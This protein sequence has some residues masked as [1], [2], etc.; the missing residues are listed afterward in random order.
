MSDTVK[1]LDSIVTRLTLMVTGIL[2][3]AVLIAG[4]VALLGQQRQLRQA[5]GTKATTLVQ[6]VAQVTPLD[7]LS[8][9]FV[10]MNNDVKKVV[11]TDDEAAYAVILNEQGIPLVSFFKDTDSSVASEVGDLVKNRKPLAAMAAMKRGGRII[12]VTAP[13]AAGEK[14]IGSVTLGLSS[15]KMRHALR[16]QIVA[17]GAVLVVII[18]LSITLLREVL[19]R[20]LRPVR[21]LT[22]AATQISAGDLNVVLTGTDRADELGVLSRAFVGMAGQL[23]GLIAGLERQL[24]FL[25]TLLQTIPMAVFYKD[26]EGRYLG[27]NEEFAKIT[28]VTKEGLAGKTVYEL[29]PGE[30]SETYHRQDLDLLKNP[31]IQVYDFKLRNAK[32]EL[33]DVEYH[34]NVFLDEKG[35][36]AGVIG[37]FLDITDRKRAEE[38]LLRERALLSRITETSPVG[39]TMANAEGTITFANRQAERM[40][41]LEKSAITQRAYN[42]PEWRI[43]DLDGGP[44]PNEQLPF[45]QVVASRQPVFD[46][47]HAIEWPNG[48]RVYLSIN[49][50]PLLSEAGEIEG[51]VFSMEDVSRKKWAEDALR[52]SEQ[53]YRD[54]FD[55]VLDGLYLLEVTPDG[56]FRTVEVNP[57]LERSTGIPRERVIGRTQ[58]ETI[59]AE[60]AAIVNAK[61]RRCVEVGAP[62]EEEVNLDLP[63]GSRYY[64]ST[65][66]PARDAAGRVNR[67]IGISRDVTEL[68]KA[69]A[70]RS[71]HLRFFESMDKVNQAIQGTNDLE[72]MMS[73]VL[74]VVLSAFNGD[75]A[76]IVYPCDPEAVSYHVPMERTTPEYP[77]ALA[78]G[79]EVPVDAETVRVFRTLL[80]SDNPVTFGPGSESPLPSDLTEFFDVHSQIAMAVYPKMDKPYMFGVHQCSY[81]RIWTAE[82]TKLLREIGR[83][84]ADALTSLLSHRDLQESEAKYRRIVDTAIEGI[85][86][87][88]PEVTTKFVNARMADML[89]HAAGEMIGRPY[90]DYMFEEDLPD[91]HQRM[92]NR[93]KGLSEAYERRFRR[94]DGNSVWTLVSATPIFDDER[95]FTGSFGMFTDI[96]E[97]KRNDSINASRL[98]LMQFAVTHSLD[99]LLEET[100]NE[101]EKVSGSLI[102]FY[103]FVDD[104]QQTL[105]LQNWSARTKAVFCK[106]A[107]KGSHYAIADAGVWVDCVYQR[108][109]VVHNDYASLPHRKGMPAGHA[110]VVRELVVPVLRGGKVKAIL[111]IGNKPADY[112]E[113]DVEV[114]ALL[115]DIAWEIAERKSAEE[116]LRRLNRQLRAISEC[117]QTLM[118]A[119]DEQTLLNDIC[120][121]I[122]DQAGYRMAWVGY[123]GQD[124]ARSVEP[125]AAA[126]IEDGYIAEARLSW[127]DTERGRGPAGMA[128]RGGTTVTVQDLSLSREFAPWLESAGKHGYRSGTW[129]PLKDERGQVFGILPI[130]SAQINAFSA[131]EIALLEELAGDLAFGIMVLR[132]RM[133]R[134]ADERSITLMNFALNNV[135]EA[136]F[137]ID[138]QAHFRYVNDESCRLLDYSREELLA[139]SVTDVDPDFPPGRWPDHWS[140]LKA[141]RSLLFEGRHQ[142]RDGR[143]VPVEISANYFEYEGEGLNLALARDI[144][145]RKRMEATLRASEQNLALHVTQTPLGVIEWNLNFEVIKWNPAAERIFGYSRR[146]ALGRHASLIVPL[147]AKEHVDEVWKALVKRKGGL[148]STNENRTKDGRRIFCEWYNTPLVDDSGSV[149]AVASLVQDVTERKEAEEGLREREAFIRDILDSVDEGF[150]VVNRDYRIVSANRAFCSSMN[151]SEDQVVGRLCHEIT[152]RLAR[153]CFEAGEDCAVRRTFMTGV[154]HIASHTHLVEGGAKQFVD[155]KSYPLTDATGRV[156]SAIETVNDVTERRK[157]EEQLRQ[158]QKMEA[159][160][161]LAGGVAHDFNNI[162]TAIIGYGSIVKMKLKSEDPLRESVDQILTASDRAAHL[163]QG[164]L[165]F[166]RKQMLNPL[167]VDLND[168]VRNVEKLLRRII[169]EDITF[170]TQLTEKSLIAMADSVQIEQVLM[171]FATNARDAMPQGG[172]L[173]ISTQEI[174]LGEDFVAMHGFGK[175]GRHALIAVS[176]TGQGMDERTREKIFDPFF[177][178]KEPGKGTGLGLAIVYG[179]IKQHNGNINVYSEPSKGSTFKIYLPLIVTAAEKAGGKDLTPPRG[180]TET[181]LLA[182]DDR[183]VRDLTATILKGYG[184]QVIEAFD[185]VDALDKYGSRSK[186]IDLLIL[187]V[188]MPRKSGKEAFD[189]IQALR[190]NVAALFISGYTADILQSRGIS[191]AGLNFI[192]K[193]VSPFELLRKVREI[194]DGRQR[195]G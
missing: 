80:G 114:V 84:L 124:E 69:G 159:I 187:D 121:I 180:G 67:I 21:N 173:T 174:D 167:P 176:D 14:R 132:G 109:P 3:T 155:L 135:R 143:I 44:F 113:K 34:K 13:I 120:R 154:A 32:G 71:A 36:V 106:A 146:E 85:W 68:R 55:N 104:D 62:V 59:S 189:A 49:G 65:L 182:E 150:I 10:E 165:A 90:T 6:F 86:V 145:A 125:V 184:Y 177:T 73:D 1:R 128:I 91:H 190:P 29:W 181:I 30:L 75:R 130:Y 42:A 23:R 166:S 57:A 185:G 118:R 64:H 112:N 164:L 148:R 175:P 172:S 96:T 100:L 87:L 82:E 61:Y 51:V 139:R 141:K 39:I 66:I 183:V 31:A 28:G 16:M 15:D 98:H 53:R 119:T 160:G 152:H 168:I 18:G 63:A 76:Y 50:A 92:E 4:S 40:L 52:A 24:R 88:G 110:D 116:S 138:E 78:K 12:E 11:L 127:A 137:L 94:K 136:A 161:T 186:E 111:G 162:L 158:A 149:I 33:R 41:G 157:L 129:L 46:V 77:G 140:E 54:I 20:M 179:I 103:H 195:S 108:K 134:K 5:L 37:A 8:L 193:P 60:A 9:N 99:D 83:R 192:S 194:L 101:A 102:G 93:R 56:R 43:T 188:I 19:R 35:S 105:T 58:E 48:R 142:A 163:T 122:C 131:G 107:G 38:A 70:E 153:P 47:R 45:Q 117:N 81:P 2:V 115:A 27:C 74:G 170:S 97:R 22:T 95:R 123:A 156:I 126:G 147:S 72:Q 144:T 169:G 25:E 7:I 89:G 178:T 133:Q 191:E 17:I 151:L 171:N 79:R 26:S